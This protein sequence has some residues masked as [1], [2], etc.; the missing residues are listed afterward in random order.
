MVHQPDHPRASNNRYVREHLL[1]AERGLGSLLPPGAEVHHVNFCRDDNSPGNLVICQE[2]AY[3]GLLHTRTQALQFSL[4]N[5]SNPV[6]RKLYKQ[7]FPTFAGMQSIHADGWAQPGGKRSI[8]KTLQTGSMDDGVE[9]VRR[10][11]LD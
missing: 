4:D 2:P 7:A 11:S 3:H 6:W 8:S 10:S 1:L 9:S 5:A